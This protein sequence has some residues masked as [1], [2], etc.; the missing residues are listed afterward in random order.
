M[1]YLG[2]V[3]SAVVTRTQ[4]HINPTSIIKD[5]SDGVYTSSLL[6]Y[7]F[8]TI[9]LFRDV[10]TTIKVSTKTERTSELPFP[11]GDSCIQW[12]TPGLR[13]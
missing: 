13:C 10:S 12:L 7:T 4:R 11:V 3:Q 6:S 1:N 2:F 8:I 5:G 9:L